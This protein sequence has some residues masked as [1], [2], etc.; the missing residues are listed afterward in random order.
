LIDE[1][2]NQLG[3]MT[4]AEALELARERELDL[5]EVAPLA[6]PPVCRIIDYGKFQYQHAKVNK[7]K[8]KKVEVKG[9][10]IGFKT[11]DHDLEVKIN[12]TAK[13]LEK[14]NKVKIEIRLKGRE[15]MHKD[16]ARENLQN[17]IKAVSAPHELEQ[18]IKPFP[19]GFNVILM[20]KSK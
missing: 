20:P 15:K 17:F 1:D 8:Q 10:R 4:P 11:D 16:K 18:E 7:V 12:Q 19:G 6:K 9:L 14:G 2:G 3:V 5:V 13:F